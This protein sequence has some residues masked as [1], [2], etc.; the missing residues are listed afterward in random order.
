MKPAVRDIDTGA[1]TDSSALA[2]P[3]GA[4]LQNQR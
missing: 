2:E 4:A 1:G 3:D